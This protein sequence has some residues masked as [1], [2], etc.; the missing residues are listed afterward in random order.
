MA[1]ASSLPYLF[2]SNV[3]VRT[4]TK[5]NSERV[6]KNCRANQIRWNQNEF[7]LFVLCSVRACGHTRTRTQALIQHTHTAL[8]I[9][10]FSEIHTLYTMLCVFVYVCVCI[11]SCSLFLYLFIL[12][13]FFSVDARFVSACRPFRSAVDVVLIIDKVSQ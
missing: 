7:F 4:R 6:K 9:S 13:L 2:N 1:L 12:L 10:C 11:K 3:R 5:K 8:L